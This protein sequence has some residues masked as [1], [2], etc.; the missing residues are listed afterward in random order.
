MIQE[1][2]KPYLDRIRLQYPKLTVVKVGALQTRE[3]APS[4]YETLGGK[5]HSDYPDN[6]NSWPVDERPLSLLVAIDPFDFE[7]LGSRSMNSKDDRVKLSIPA[8]FA[9][10]F[11]NS[12]LHGGGANKSGRIVYRLF[13]Y[14]VSQQAHILINHVYIETSEEPSMPEERVVCITK[15]SKRTAFRTE[16]LGFTETK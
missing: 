7:M 15:R 12:C 11:T 1:H 8:G 16:R 10:L 4:Q 13:A 14:I 6:S 5:L 2:L 9:A 3:N